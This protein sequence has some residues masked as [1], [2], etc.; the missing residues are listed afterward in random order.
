MATPP[1]AVLCLSSYFKGNRFLQRCRRDGCPVYLL[2]LDKLRDAAWAR[3]ALDD[4]FVMPSLDDRR[5]VVN[6]VAYLLRDK[7]IDRV[8][9]LDEFDVETAAHLREH[10]RL[11]GLGESQARY[12]RDKLAMRVRARENDLPVPE[13][14][15]VI[16]HEEIRRFLAR[17][18]APWLLKPRTEA[19]AIGI[20]KFHDADAVW[21]RLNE[22]GD[23]QS[24]H[25]LER[26]I[27]G[28]VYHVDTLSADGR[29]RIVEVNCYQRPLL[30][31]WQGGG[32]FASRTVPRDTPEVA[33]L[34]RLTERLLTAFG[35]RDGP[36]HTEY[37]RAHADGAFYFLETSARVGGAYIAEMVE[38]AT[39]L[40]LWEEWAALEIQGGDYNLPPVRAEYG[41]VIASLARQEKPDTSGFTD[42]EIFY[43]VDLK[44]HIGL[45][46]RADRPERVEELLADY[47]ARI[48]RDFQAVLPATDRASL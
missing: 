10:F 34:R 30:D 32:V 42:P 11:P 24:F 23:S 38:A 33:A 13:F 6:A 29:L 17:V 2:T 27:P 48:A 47:A 35:L 15:G 43:R 3:D 5:A 46:V 28:D 19:S 36:S 4:L 18:P 37:L 31:I 12:F 7:P 26:F 44:N 8:V 45:V 41:G 20:Q 14:V 1:R 25:L 40:N 22:L 16:N 39:G 21:R 9:A